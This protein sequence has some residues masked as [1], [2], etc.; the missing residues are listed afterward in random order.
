MAILHVSKQ[1]SNKSFLKVAKEDNVFK[2]IIKDTEETLCSGTFK[3]CRYF[4]KGYDTA[5]TKYVD[6]RMT[7]NNKEVDYH[8][9]E[10]LLSLEPVTP[11]NL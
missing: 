5:S 9:I 2:V 7:C 4:I 6:L 10:D 3:E 11:L 8:K 1:S